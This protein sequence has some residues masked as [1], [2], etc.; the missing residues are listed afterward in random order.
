M[1]V[2]QLEQELLAYV[3]VIRVVGYALLGLVVGMLAGL[4][5]VGGGFLLTPLLNVI[6]GLPYNLAVG[7]GLVQMA[8][9][10]WVG[11]RQHMKLGHVDLKLGASLLAG[12]FIG[13]ETGVR[14]QKTLSAIG[15]VTIGGRSV[16]GFDLSMAFLFVV[17]LGSLG[18]AMLVETQKTSSRA[19]RGSARSEQAATRDDNND[20]GRSE[21]SQSIMA[22]WIAQVQ[23]RPRF[24][25]S[26]DPDRQM[27]LWVPAGIGFFVAILTGLLGVGGGFIN[28]PVLIY[29]LNLPTVV[30]VGTASLITSSV[31]VYSGARYLMMGMVL[32]PVVISL[33]LGS[34]VGV[35]Y[36]ARLSARIPNDRLRRAFAYTVLTTAA[37][38]VVDS[39]R[40]ML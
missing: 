16:S 11:T 8:A 10:S 4:F 1:R 29:V 28:M 12:S 14:V 3:D 9:M 13:A 36:G 31:A 34:F 23:A 38:V 37:I 22:R 32:W 20:E 26:T 27:S 2:E 17:L 35:R 39:I 33:W 40:K 19:V 24:T 25:L 30:A 6:F 15:D 18:W 7:S 21:P 5:G